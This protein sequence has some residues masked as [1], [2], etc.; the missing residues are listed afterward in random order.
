M[1]SIRMPWAKLYLNQTDLAQTVSS[2]EVKIAQ[3]DR[4]G[5]GAILGLFDKFQPAVNVTIPV[6]PRAD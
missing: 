1:S 3:G 4:D 6:P 2:A 5:V